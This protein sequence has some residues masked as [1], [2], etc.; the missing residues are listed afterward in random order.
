MAETHVDQQLLEFIVKSI[1]SNPDAVKV[2]R[3]VDE[4]GVLLTLKVDSSDM[5]QVIGRE[6]S[7]AKAANVLS[8][9]NGAL[10]LRTLQSINDL[11]SDQSNTIIFA[12]PL[13]IL[14]S[15]EGFGKSLLKGNKVNDMEANDMKK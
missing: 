9:A 5:A 15:F 14:R 4:M 11:S 12:V 13:E 7:M 2:E 8:S 6:G 3:K 1:A 10:H